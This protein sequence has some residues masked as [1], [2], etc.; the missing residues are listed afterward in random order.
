MGEKIAVIDSG[1]RGSA[2][3]RGYAR[4]PRVESVLAIPGNDLMKIG[5][6][7]SVETFP[8]VKTTDVGA[9]V[10][11]CRD[12][13]ISFVDVAQDNAVERGLVDAL[14]K[15]GI[16][17]LGPRRIAGIIEWS[18]VFARSFGERHSLLQPEWHAFASENGA[19]SHA[20]SA[21]GKPMFIKADGLC[22]GKGAIPARNTTEAIGAIKE[23]KNFKNGA[24]R[25]FL[26]EDWMKNEDGTDGEE[27]S[28]FAI[29][30]GRNVA[31][32]GYAQDHKRANNF[33]E[34]ANT[35]GTGCVSKPMVLTD[36]I[37]AEVYG[38]FERTITGL[39]SE[40]RE[41]RGIIYLGGMLIREGG[42]LRPY[43]VEF[44][45]R[46][47]DP[48]T[49]AILPGIKN[50]L[51]LMGAKAA[52]GDLSRIKIL[53]DG[54]IRVTVAGM[55]RGYPGDYSAARGKEIFGLERAMR[56]DGVEI[57]GAGVKV[58]DGHY[59]ANG[60][61]LFYV[62]GEGRNAI[63]AREKAYS[64]LAGI[65]IEGNNLHY[66]TDIGWRDVERLN[67]ARRA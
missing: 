41:Y 29:S 36:D 5:Q 2:L 32:L 22:E 3:V 45:S 23:M 17:A 65:S 59:F 57:S 30:D 55:S 66:R 56:L 9:I 51:F 67:L 46:W 42:V 8:T 61:R 38:I 15:A 12:R 31:I 33:D 39:K 10:Q 58:V 26:V 27:F 48:E 50:D 20:E 14:Q 16:L 34:G 44:N 64:A 4:S 28:A 40:K 35:G 18:K 6:H 49:Q 60:G 63:E 1:G 53:H 21:Q 13:K 24:G 43:V 19:I 47:G 52:S 11:I 62:T 25:T 7:K 37:K 54:K